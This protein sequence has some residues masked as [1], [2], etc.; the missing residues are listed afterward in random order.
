QLHSH[1]STCFKHMP[2]SIRSLRNDDKDC[3]FQMPCDLVF[4]TYIDEDGHIHIKCTNS[5]INGF[6]DICVLCLCCNMDINYIGSGTA[7]MAMVQY[8]TNYI[9]KLSFDSST[10]FSALCAAIKSVTSSPPID[11]TTDNID[12]HEQSRLLLLKSCNAMI[13]KRELSGQQVASFLCNIPNRFTNHHFDK[14]WW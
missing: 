6:N 8:V 1:S 2:K 4:E 14:L 13:G 7:A 9:A 12:V 10:V 5:F 11:P 3:R